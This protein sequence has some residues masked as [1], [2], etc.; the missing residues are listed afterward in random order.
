MRNVH[1]AMAP[2]TDALI[3]RLIPLHLH[4]DTLDHSFLLQ[5]VAFIVFG[6]DFWPER[7]PITFFF[8]Y[9]TIKPVLS[10]SELDSAPISKFFDHNV[11]EWLNEENTSSISPYPYEI[12][13]RM[14]SSWH[15]TYIKVRKVNYTL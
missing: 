1:T 13:I 7:E 4:Q 12:F 5:F 9:I 8:F 15:V 14:S 11:V 2:T 6:W 10:A 3:P